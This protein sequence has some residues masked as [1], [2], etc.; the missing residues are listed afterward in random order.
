M[1]SEHNG[2]AT[3]FKRDIPQLFSIHCIAHCD[4]LAISD[5]FKKIKQSAFLKKLANRVYDWIGMSSFQN[6]EL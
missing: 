5:T 6:G 3:K 1:K 2:F 4:T